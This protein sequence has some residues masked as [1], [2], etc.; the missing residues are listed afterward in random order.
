MSLFR[1]LAAAAV[2]AI[3][4]VAAH[5][6]TMFRLEVGPAV[7]AGFAKDLKKADGKKLVLAVRA[8][9]CD[10]LAGVQ[11]SG[12]AEGL[13]N[14]TRQSVPLSLVTV[15][16]AAAIYA[17]HQQW[18][19]SGSWVLHLKGTC[20]KPKGEASTLVPMN[21]GTFIRE[22][23]EVLREPATM[24]QVESALAALSRSQS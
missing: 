18:P 21:K 23:T 5:A 7:A 12:T 17:L 8:L 19:E 4:A 20:S 24:K 1:P 9:V 14:G 16:K 15:D 13:V 22:K 3:V 2:V 6:G 10:D 11:I